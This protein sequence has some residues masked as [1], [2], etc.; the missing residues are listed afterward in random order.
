MWGLKLTV[1]ESPQNSGAS[2]T[3]ERRVGEKNLR[4]NGIYFWSGNEI[5][6]IQQRMTALTDVPDLAPS[7]IQSRENVRLRRIQVF[8][9]SKNS[10]SCRTDQSEAKVGIKYL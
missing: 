7:S 3:R 4:C 2:Q 5:K 9:N 6:V 8:K 1:L 10:F